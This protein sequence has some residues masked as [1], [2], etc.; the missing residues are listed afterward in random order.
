M[1]FTDYHTHTC[2]SFDGAPH[3]TIDAMCQAAIDRGIS[4]LAITDHMDI[5]HLQKYSYILDCGHL[6]PDLLDAK[7]RYAGKLKVVI[8]AELGQPMSNP[9]E[10][11]RFL[12]DHPELD[13]VI[14]SV[15]QMDNDLDV[16]YYNFR[17]HDPVQ[18]YDQYLDLL[19]TYAS[20][21]DYDVIGHIT[22]PLR[23]MAE[24]G[25]AVNIRQFL[26]KI[27]NLYRVIIRRDRGIELNLSGFRQSMQTTMPTPRLLKLYH[28][29]GGR[30]LTLGSDAHCPE[31]VGAF[32]R[33]GQDIAYECGFRELTTFEKRTPSFHRIMVL[34]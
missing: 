14:G 18:V 29:C 13:F 28:D 26:E 23:Y 10:G 11:R 9:R 3:A 4:E 33:A 5:F 24:A 8:G 7:D 30:I 19:T 32:L 17:K 2:F 12:S 25:F 31:D 16:Y 6:Y 22:Y 27:E 1:Y 34:R 21:Y 15:H 20:E